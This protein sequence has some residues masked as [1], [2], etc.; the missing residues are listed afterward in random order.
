MYGFKKKIEDNEIEGVDKINYPF[1]N[2]KNIPEEDYSFK[3][4]N[5]K[6]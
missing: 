4:I 3:K 2:V 5:Y 1:P 6:K